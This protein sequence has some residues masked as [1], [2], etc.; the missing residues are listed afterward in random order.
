[1]TSAE[2]AHMQDLEGKVKR[3]RSRIVETK[4]KN[5]ALTAALQAMKTDRDAKARQV[6]ALYEKHREFIIALIRE[7]CGTADVV[8]VERT[9]YDA[10]ESEVVVAMERLMDLPVNS[11]QSL[12]YR[13]TRIYPPPVVRT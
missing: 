10:Y 7:K 12:M 4:E 9:L 2:H 5:A 8:Y 6:E 13:A 11:E 1:M 3:Y